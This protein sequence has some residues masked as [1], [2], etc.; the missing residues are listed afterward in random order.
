M[1]ADAG[2][3]AEYDALRAKTDADLLAMQ[4][5]DF[6]EFF[7]SDAKIV[8]DQL[9]LKLS[10]KPSGGEQHPMAGVPVSEIE[11]YAQAL[12]ERG[13]RLAIATQGD[14][15]NG[16]ERSIDRIVTP[17]TTL[18]R[19]DEGAGY[20]GVIELDGATVGLALV[21][22][23]AG[24]WYAD[25]PHAAEDTDALLE[26]IGGLELAEVV[27]SPRIESVDTLEQHLGV[28]VIQPDGDH[29]HH[30]QS[31]ER[32]SEHFG[33][34]VIETLELDGVTARA[35]GAALTYIEETDPSLLA[36]L[37]RLQRYRADDAVSLDATT[38]RNLELAAT[39]H[40]ESEGSLIETIDHTV[41]AGGA[42]LLREWI[43]HPIRDTDEL[44][45]R[46]DA[47]EALYTTPLEREN[48]ATELEPIYDLDRLATR[49][50]HGSA[51]PAALAKIRDTLEVLPRL[52]DR[53]ERS[54]EL[55]D[56]PVAE[57]L[58]DPPW[59]ELGELSDILDSAL[60]EDPPVTTSEGGI[61]DTGWDDDLDDL[62]QEHERLQEWFDGLAEREANRHG[63]EQ[64]SVDD[65]RTDGY[66]IQIAESDVE[67]VPDDYERIKAV[68]AGV[69][70]KTD[71]LVENE[72]RFREFEDRRI[73][74]EQEAFDYLLDEIAAYVPALRAAATT[75]SGLDVRIALAEHAARNDWNRPTF[76]S[77]DVIEIDQG[78]HPV[79][80][81]TTRFVPN[82]CRLDDA[83]RQL[84][85]TGPNMSGKSTYLRQVA[86]IIL[87]AQIGSFV[88][89]DRAAIS[90]VD[91]IYTRVGA[92][93]E[94]AQGRS[95]FMVEMQELA[96]ILH[97]ATDRSLVVLD[98]VGRGTSTYDG[99]SIAWATTEYLHNEVGANALF[100]THYHEL[101][102]LGEHLE[103]V[104]NCHVGVDDNGEEVVFLRTIQPGPTD[105]SYGI[106]VADLAGVPNPVVQRADEVLSRLRE[107]KAIEARGR[108]AEGTQVVFDLETG[109]MQ[110]DGDEAVDDQL[111]D[112][113]EEV[114]DE[115]NSLSLE[116]T[117]PLDLVERVQ[118]WQ[119]R[120]ED[121]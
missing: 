100:A 60:V 8:H 54:V 30:R 7:G 102:A 59:E 97:R 48:L 1:G 57:L 38:Q 6:F 17:G 44:E 56:S 92:L 21:D 53:I 24:Q 12:V 26:I 45:R 29:F 61:F 46:I 103:G 34:E 18:N 88:P 52:H 14:S 50:A 74:L 13:F 98:E 4:V 70:F 15:S 105:R 90:P 101:T 16:H 2:I 20:L 118:G 66:Y 77:D 117:T 31:I 9:D 3:V 27:V 19:S 43:R 104:A 72:R 69:R 109:Q 36:S 95:T 116:A 99:M 115:I 119:E 79:V 87:L 64:V 62:I 67:R 112:S 68:A 42:R 106:H 33:S 96:R 86:L 73:A 22:V 85:V 32:V 75:L 63:F 91:G 5:G 82:D 35:V 11:R 111:P 28:P 84:L 25:R 55:A 40:G 121:D 89:A 71:E 80:E 78:R 83:Q 65:N 94:L 10:E 81:Q 76:R 39:F 49:C 23:A 120:L 93:D 110:P 114:I 51:T 37:T 41:T 58:D 47:V 113:I 108:R 107:E